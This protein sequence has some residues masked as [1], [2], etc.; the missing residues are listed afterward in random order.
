MRSFVYMDK[1]IR[2]T[3]VRY[4]SDLQII[5]N[6]IKLFLLKIIKPFFSIAIILLG[7]YIAGY[8]ILVFVIFFILLY[9]Y[10]KIKSSV[11]NR[12]ES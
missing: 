6:K 4:Q 12:E 9:F 11:N 7:L 1:Q 2:K 3:E 10:N 5:F 8:V